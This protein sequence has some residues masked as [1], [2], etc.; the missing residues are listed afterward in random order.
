MAVRTPI[1]YRSLEAALLLFLGQI[2]VVIDQPSATRVPMTVAVVTGVRLFREGLARLLGERVICHAFDAVMPDEALVSRIL[3][4]RPDVILVDVATIRSG[5][6]VRKLSECAAAARIV[7]FAVAECEEDM[8]MCVQL[9]VAGLVGR[10]A[11]TEELLFAIEGARRGELHC[12]PRL[13]SLLFG[14]LSLLTRGAFPPESRLTARQQE[15]VRLLE[16]GLT[17]KQI[18]SRLGLT[19]STVK[20]HVHALLE[21][22]N[23]RHRWQAMAAARAVDARALPM[24]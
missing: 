10:D 8:A 21:R 3:A 1:P 18:A 22:L 17:N 13:A 4:L 15:I 19:E 12:S 9:G 2:C 23:V 6:L 14:R 5:G 11:S 24:G 20:N 7:A 16:E